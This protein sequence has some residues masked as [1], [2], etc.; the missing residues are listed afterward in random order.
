LLFVLRILYVIILA[1]TEISVR[2]IPIAI[3]ERISHAQDLQF[4]MHFFHPPPFLR[5]RHVLILAVNSTSGG[6]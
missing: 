5:L 1:M 4:V 6:M 3:E 2:P